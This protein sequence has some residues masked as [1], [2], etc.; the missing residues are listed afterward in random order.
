[1]NGWMDSSY[2]KSINCV[3][4]VLCFRVRVEEMPNDGPGGQYQTGTQDGSRLGVF[5]VNLK[6]PNET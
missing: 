4:P 2:N 3:Y 6:R 1:M 5:Q